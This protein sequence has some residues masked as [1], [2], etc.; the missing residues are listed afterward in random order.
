[1]RLV[2]AIRRSEA[3]GPTAMFLVLLAVVIALK[4]GRYSL[5]DAQNLAAN[6][7]PL[8]LVGL[9]QYFVILVRGIDLSLGPVM[10]VSS[11]LAAVLFPY[12]AVPA[13]AAAIAGGVAAGIGNGLL[14]A[15]LDLSPVI[16]TLATMSVW[17]GVSLVVLATPGGTIP[18]GL[19]M[20]LTAATVVVPVPI[21]LLIATA[22]FG[23]WVMSTRLGLHLRAIGGDA[24]A[25]E[26]SGVRV[27]RQRFAA[28]A[29]AGT[30]AALGGL[31]SAIATSAGSPIIGD[32]YILPSIA[33]VVLGGVPLIGGRGSP[34][35]VVMGALTLNIIGSL[36]YFA[37]LSDFYQ[38]LIN[39]VILIAVVAAAALRS[40]VWRAV[41]A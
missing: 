23:A 25:A 12:G 16:V 41:P 2:E 31:Y 26:A 40:W 11:C 39:G 1:M 5:F 34:V 20:A 4:G 17:Q 27:R 33:A 3:T 38:S 19:Q 9:G 37:N 32:S 22:L 15:W 10:S 18:A 6:V 14:V 8:A 36:L 28:Y 35:G 30:L 29:L 21:L 7:L 13:I 24:G